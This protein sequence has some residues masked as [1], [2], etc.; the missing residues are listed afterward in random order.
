M[1]YFHDKLQYWVVTKWY[2]KSLYDNYFF[3]ILL[4]R[5]RFT[6]NRF[7][8]FSFDVNAVAFLR[9]NNNIIKFH[10]IWTLHHKGRTFSKRSVICYCF[11]V[12]R[13]ENWSYVRL[14]Y[15]SDLTYSCA[16]KDS[17]TEIIL[18]TGILYTMT[19][20]RWQFVG[21]SCAWK[22]KRYMRISIL[23]MYVD[24]WRICII[25][26]CNFVVSL[27]QVFLFQNAL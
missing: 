1:E 17:Q 12:A 23:P 20:I 24:I 9:N 11:F 26:R 25:K 3:S 16:P 15:F 4:Q 21:K 2:N 5:N 13:T 10:F 19:L 14:K 6:W 27:A 18:A 7:C 8:R 22:R